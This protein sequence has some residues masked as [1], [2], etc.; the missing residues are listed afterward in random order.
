MGTNTTSGPTAPITRDSPTITGPSCTTER[1]PFPRTED[2]RSALRA[3]KKSANATASARKTSTR[4]ED[5]TA[6]REHGDLI[7]ICLVFDVRNSR[8]LLSC[9]SLNLKLKSA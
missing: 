7:L 5:C 9:S 3:A 2:R 4:L 6:V 1:T 8:Y